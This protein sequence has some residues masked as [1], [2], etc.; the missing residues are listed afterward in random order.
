MS[1]VGGLGFKLPQTGSS[2]R[3]VVVVVAVVVG[4]D[5]LLSSQTEEK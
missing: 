4:V 3:C 1:F 2:C 5:S